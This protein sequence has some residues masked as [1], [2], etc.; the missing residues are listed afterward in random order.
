MKGSNNLQAIKVEKA[1]PA[2]FIEMDH[3]K[4][5]AVNHQPESRISVLAI[6]LYRMYQTRSFP[7]RLRYG[8]V[9]VQPSQ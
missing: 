2:D 9:E 3:V 4:S 6:L 5:S 7:A 8:A 1:D